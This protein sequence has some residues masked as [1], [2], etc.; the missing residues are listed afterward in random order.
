M[1][2]FVKVAETA[3]FAQAARQLHMSAPAVTRAVASL[4]EATGARLFVRS[5]RSVKLTPSG[6]RYADDCRRILGDIDEAEASAGGSHATASGILTITAPVLFGQIYVIPIMTE[7]LSLHPAVTGRALFFDRMVNL[8]EEGIDVAVRIGHLQDSDQQAVRVG[9]V[10]RVVCGAPGYFERHGEPTT[11]ADLA[12][13]VTIVNTGSS[14]PLEWHFAPGHAPVKLHPRMY[15]NTVGA[16]I[17]AAV[18]GWGLSRTLSYQVAEHL[19]AGRLKTVIEEYE[20]EPLPIHV[21]HVEGRHV[22]AKT[23]AF[24]DFVAQ[25]IKALGL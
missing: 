4:E 20:E 16:S 24:V 18:T 13:H 17:E 25:K 9:S 6:S 11:P 12:R 21:V 7:F 15:C 1:R 3:S 10:R 22:S 5:T 8:V 23:R 2:V 14:A 19:A